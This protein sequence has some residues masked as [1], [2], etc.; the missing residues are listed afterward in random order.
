MKRL[1]TGILLLAMA[2]M[3]AGCVSRG[4]YEGAQ[5]DLLTAEET[6]S[7]QQAQIAEL[8]NELDRADE[9]LGTEQGRS[10]ELASSLEQTGTELEETQ[11][12]LASTQITL[13]DTQGVVEDARTQLADAREQLVGFDEL[14]S[15]FYAM[16]GTFEKSTDTM[17]HAPQSADDRHNMGLWLI[18]LASSQCVRSTLSD[19]GFRVGTLGSSTKYI[20]SRLSYHWCA[21]KRVNT[22][23]LYLPSREPWSALAAWP[24]QYKSLFPFSVSFLQQQSVPFAFLEKDATSGLIRAVIVAER[25]VD[26]IDLI[27]KMFTREVLIGVPW[28]V[29]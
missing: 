17:W 6:V 29:N 21:I 18:G 10:A 27:T 2:I 24:T 11:T 15:L 7:D 20:Y 16:E 22:V 8:T 23:F 13:A 1:T 4:T 12:I 14:K 28:T 25:D 19:L 9:A 5:Q 3:L 26:F